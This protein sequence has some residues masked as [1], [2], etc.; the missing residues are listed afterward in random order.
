MALIDS[1]NKINDMNHAFAAKLGL[2][3]CPTVNCA[4]KINGSALK[5]YGMTIAGF[6]I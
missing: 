6:S 2:S 4:Q 3:I 1:G 5:T